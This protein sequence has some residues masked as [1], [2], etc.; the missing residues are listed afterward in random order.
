MAKSTI[1]SKGQIT[2]PRVIRD[3]LGIGSG[4]RVA[5][6][7]RDGGEV[8]VE[9]ETVDIRS[10]R[11]MLKRRGRSVTLNQMNEAIRKGGTRQ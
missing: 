3:H 6:V 10:L 5:F 1:T 2:L 4:D 7:I 8:L 11:G 9:A